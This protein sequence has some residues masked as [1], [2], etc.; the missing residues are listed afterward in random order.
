MG[1]SLFVFDSFHSE[2][3]ELPFIGWICVAYPWKRSQVSFSDVALKK[4]THWWVSPAPP[5]KLKVW[6][7]FNHFQPNK[8]PHVFRNVM[9]PIYFLIYENWHKMRATFN[10]PHRPT[11]WLTC[12]DLLRSFDPGVADFFSAGAGEDIW[13]A[14]N[15]LGC[16]KGKAAAKSLD[17]AS[18]GRGWNSDKSCKKWRS[19]SFLFLPFRNFQNRGCND[20][21]CFSPIIV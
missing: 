15:P 6:T 17:F 16:L 11:K 3:M 21:Q 19:G 1:W 7:C 5:P 4:A 12:Q 13:E 14:G 18:N 10:L 9:F 8:S 2:F 20:T